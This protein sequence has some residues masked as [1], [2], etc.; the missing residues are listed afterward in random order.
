MVANTFFG[1][2]VDETLAVAD[3]ERVR[4]IELRNVRQYN[5]SNEKIGK[6]SVIEGSIVNGFDSPRELIRIEANLYDAEGRVLVTKSVL[7]GT[8]A[9]LFQLQVLGEQELEQ[10]LSNS[11]D[12]LANNS[13]VQP[14]G[15]VP[16]MVLFYNPPA[17]AVEFGVKVVDARTVIS[18]VEPIEE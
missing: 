3:V 5:V 11:I 12:I 1:E 8:S 13:N 9:S 15:V 18:E 6:I 16:F 10:A 2:E 17:D 14:G 4:L 7:A